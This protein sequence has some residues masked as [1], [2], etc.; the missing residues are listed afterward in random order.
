MNDVYEQQARMLASHSDPDAAPRSDEPLDV[1]RTFRSSPTRVWDRIASPAGAATW[2]GEEPN[3][4][5]YGTHA[6][7]PEV[8]DVLDLPSREEFEVHEIEPGSRIRL[9]ALGPH[10]AAGSTIQLTITG[11]SGRA[12]VELDHDGLVDPQLRAGMREHW[13]RVLGRIGEL[14]DE[15]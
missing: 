1:H 13:E 3:D 2:L 5:W 12:V 6:G 4:W 8:G 7:G 15:A 14:L 10:L 11:S 9:R